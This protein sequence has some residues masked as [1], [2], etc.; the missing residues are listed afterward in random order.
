LEVLNNLRKIIENKINSCSS[1]E[2]EKYEL[3]KEILKEDDCF[4]KIDRIT[5]YS[6]LEDLGIIDFDIPIIYN[7]LIGEDMYLKI[8]EKYILED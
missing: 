7:K 2:L 4:F 1:D 6:I 5:A 3:I 8:N